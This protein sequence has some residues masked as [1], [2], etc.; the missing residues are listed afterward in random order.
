MERDLTK[1]D[2]MRYQLELEIA[3]PRGRVVALFL[4]PDNLQQWQPDLVSFEQIGSGA[5]REVGAKSKQVHRMGKREI[6]IMETITIHSPPEVFAAIYEAEGVSNLISNR[7]TETAEGA[8]RWVLDA[9]CKFSSL[10][11]KLMAWL[12]PG[13]FR[14]QTRTFMQR[15]KEFAEKSV[16]EG[17]STSQSF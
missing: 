11:L 3:A 16:R 12:M 13:M 14:K 6:E 7:F 10:M 17:E 9:H 8:T 5:P 15:F 2:T 4:D 1:A